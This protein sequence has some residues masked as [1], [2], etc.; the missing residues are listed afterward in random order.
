MALKSNINTIKKPYPIGIIGGGQLALMLLEAAKARGLKVC[1]QTKSED[2]PAS[3]KADSVVFADPIQLKGNKILLKDCEKIIFENEWIN[4]DKLKQLE[5]DNFFIPKLDALAP[6]VDRISQKQFLNNLNLPSPKW[7]TVKKFKNLDEES[8]I[9]LSFP[10]MAK[11]FKGGYDGKG[12][13][14]ISNLEELNNFIDQSNSEDWI[15]EEWINYT[16]DMVILVGVI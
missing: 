10:L 2:D 5:T 12:N 15:L 11:S 8:I 3:L 7:T 9:N 4:I 14:K 16:N 13:K 6:L 1:I